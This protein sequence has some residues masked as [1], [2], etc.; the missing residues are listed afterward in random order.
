MRSDN[1]LNT[2]IGLHVVSDVQ[3]LYLKCWTRCS[4]QLSLTY[5]KSR[6]LI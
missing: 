1:G 3:M 5:I 6:W 2:S 4:W